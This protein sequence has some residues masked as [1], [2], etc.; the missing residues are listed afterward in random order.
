MKKVQI[1]L[2]VTLCVT[3]CQAST[4]MCDG[5]EVTKGQAIVNLATN[6]SK[7]CLKIDKMEFNLEK[8]SLKIKK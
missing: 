5:K 8:G 6:K 7:E 4:F 3:L 1:I 2:A